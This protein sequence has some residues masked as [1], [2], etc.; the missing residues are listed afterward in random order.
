MSLVPHCDL[1]GEGKWSGTAMGDR[2]VKG[3][4]TFVKTLFFLQSF[5][6]FKLECAVAFICRIYAGMNC[7]YT[8]R[9]HSNGS[10]RVVLLLYFYLEHGKRNISVRNECT[11]V[12][13]AAFKLELE[14]ASREIYSL[15]L[16]GFLWI[17]PCESLVLMKVALE[18]S[19][20]FSLAP[21]FS[22]TMVS[23][24]PESVLDTRSRN[25]P[26]W[27]TCNSNHEELLLLKQ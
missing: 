13:S 10:L 19:C 4:R 2:N 1:R 17:S 8:H 5:F 20:V 26:L 16:P 22:I 23:S 3:N 11:L 21:S 12:S 25:F 24:L 6:M 7:T 27:S 15:C 18:F 14:V 9:P